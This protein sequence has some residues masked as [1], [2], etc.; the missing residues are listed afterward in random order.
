[1]MFGMV[2]FSKLGGIPGKIRGSGWNG[3]RMGFRTFPA[4]RT[5]ISSVFIRL[6]KALEMMWANCCSIWP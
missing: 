2:R 4:F 6:R 1:M 5:L 3:G